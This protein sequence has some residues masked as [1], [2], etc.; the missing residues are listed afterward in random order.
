MFWWIPVGLALGV[1][2][3]VMA[4]IIARKGRSDLGFVSARWIAEHRV[5][6]R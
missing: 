5:D 1:A 4:F 6:P 3:I 2:V